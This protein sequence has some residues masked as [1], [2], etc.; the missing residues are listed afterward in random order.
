MTNLRI[1]PLLLVLLVPA[2]ITA[3]R[4]PGEADG[5]SS[6]SVS[7]GEGLLLDDFEEGITK[8]GQ[9]WTA[10]VDSNNLGSEANYAVE[11]GGKSGKAGH[12]KGKVGRN[13]APWPWA[14][15][16]TG[17]GPGA[18]ADLSGV[19]AVRFWIKGDGKKYRLALAREA[20]TDYANFA[21][22]F[23]APTEWTQM[24]IKLSELR[25]ASWGKP[26]ERAW[27]DVKVLEFGAMT[28]DS[29]FDV[30]I[31]NVEL[32]IEPGK[33]PPFGANAKSID[34]PQTP[35][36]GTAYV[37]DKFEGTAPANG[38][39]WGS[40]MDMNNLGTI[41]TARPED[42]GGE[43][44][45][46]IH[47]TGKLGKKMTAWPWATL[48]INLEPN[49]TPVDLTHCKGIRFKAKGDGRPYKLAI[50]RKAVSDYGNF[51]YMFSPGKDWKQY[52][53][54]L[55]KLQQPDWAVKVEEGWKDATSLQFAPT[56]NETPFDLWVDDVEFVFE[57]GK[58]IPFPNK[59]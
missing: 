43:Q 42:S 41:A 48:A 46:A 31:D 34:E 54:P 29:P 2:C 1:S 11:D 51:S 40:E 22:E 30:Y 10:G 5:E 9:P 47:L 35:L 52:S 59:K 6:A 58:T 25:Q 23:D 4:P 18:K 8:A 14:A 50:T 12:F 21:K 33:A 37:L 3:A 53:V 24:E 16:T 17:V 55:S 20:V 39:V 44:K 27:N 28:P 38:A 7:G 15:L 26:V 36:E 49:A 56:V 57:N 19:T 45:N 32:V 13:V